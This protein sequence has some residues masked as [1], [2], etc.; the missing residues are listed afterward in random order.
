MSFFLR[1]V[2]GKHYA[3]FRF[4]RCGKLGTLPC[5]STGQARRLALQLFKRCVILLPYR[6]LLR[7]ITSLTVS[8]RCT[9]CVRFYSMYSTAAFYVCSYMYSIYSMQLRL[10][11]YSARSGLVYASVLSI[12]FN[13]H[14]LTLANL[15]C[16]YSLLSV[17][18]VLGRFVPTYCRRSVRCSPAAFSVLCSIHQLCPLRSL[19]AVLC[20]LPSR[21]YH[22]H[23]FFCA[24]MYLVHKPFTHDLS[25]FRLI[26]LF[27]ALFPV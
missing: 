15:R 26:A 25:F 13:V 19:V 23:C 18:S 1:A 12:L 6:I 24:L 14:G 3:D 27:N 21:Y 8:S 2:L 10:E 4:G 22:A 16:M 7:G 9:F 11:V 5:D 20:P 17:Y